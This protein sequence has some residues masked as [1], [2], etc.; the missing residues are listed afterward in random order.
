MSI[1]SSCECPSVLSQSKICGVKIRKDTDLSLLRAWAKANG[2]KNSRLKKILKQ[3]KRATTDPEFSERVWLYPQGSI[4]PPLE[5]LRVEIETVSDFFQE[6]YTVEALQK[7]EFTE[8]DADK[9]FLK[10]LL[11]RN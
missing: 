6:L 3:I 8:E 9:I 7:S 4:D 11:G 10:S 5:L 1:D 2:V